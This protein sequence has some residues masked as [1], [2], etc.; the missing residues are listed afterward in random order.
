[1]PSA[2]PKALSLPKH[3]R[4]LHCRGRLL[5]SKSPRSHAVSTFGENTPST[6]RQQT[7]WDDPMG[8]WA[9]PARRLA[10]IETAGFA[11]G[12]PVHPWFSWATRPTKL[13]RVPPT[14]HRIRTCV[15]PRDDHVSNWHCIHANRWWC[16][17][18]RTPPTLSGTK[19]SKL[20]HTR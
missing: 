15:Q 4:R 20:E 7:D 12:P 5:R 9:V 13:D 14:V 1:M 16:N 19:Y 2:I 8:P 18:F 3:S 6:A 17:P 10:C 11:L